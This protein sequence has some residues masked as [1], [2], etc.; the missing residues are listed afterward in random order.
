MG[1]K[2]ERERALSVVRLQLYVSLFEAFGGHM[3]S[4]LWACVWMAK[5][6]TARRQE[7]STIISTS[8]PAQTAQGPLHVDS[9]GHSHPKSIRMAKHKQFTGRF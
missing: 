2:K 5:K 9:E 8:K 6:N 7:V 4:H 1:E 3:S